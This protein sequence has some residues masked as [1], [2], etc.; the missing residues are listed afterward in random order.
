MMLAQARRLDWAITD[1]A[2]DRP[3]SYLP[4]RRASNLIMG[5]TV[6]ML[7][8][9]MIGKRL[10][11]LLAPF[12]L[13]LIAARR[14]ASGPEGAV[15]IIPTTQIDARLA[16]ADHVIN[17]LPG[18]S[19]T[20]RFMNAAKF[21]AMKPGSIFYNLG[22][23]STV[24]QPALIAA[25]QSGH[26]G[27]AWLDVT[28]PEPLPPNDPLWQAPRCHITPHTA[29]GHATEFHRLTEHFLNNLQRYTSGREL[30]GRVI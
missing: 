22:R 18:G 24:D 4:I 11:E 19:A 1:Q 29:G 25:L 5:Q 3:W 27:A 15:E 30:V 13:R 21:S 10:A 2:G 8:F 28:V 9:G 14:N 12:N 17:I 23:G 20:E 7:G 16:E 6:L 26:L